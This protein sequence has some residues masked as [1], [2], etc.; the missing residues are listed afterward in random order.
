MAREEGYLQ[1]ASLFLETA[2]NEREHA[3][4]FFSL[5]GGGDVEFTAAYPAGPVGT[6]LDNL[7]YAAEG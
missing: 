2:E 7:E 3:R 6:T 4:V 1:I 5:L